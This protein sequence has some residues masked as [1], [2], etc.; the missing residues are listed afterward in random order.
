M[1]VPKNQLIKSIDIKLFWVP[2]NILKG[3]DQTS[4][5]WVPIPPSM[6]ERHNPLDFRKGVLPTAN[7]ISSS[8]CLSLAQ[9]KCWKVKWQF[10]WLKTLLQAISLFP[11]SN[12]TNLIGENYFK[13]CCKSW[14]LVIRDEDCLLSWVHFS[15]SMKSLVFWY[16]VGFLSNGFCCILC[17]SL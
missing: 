6:A 14:G 17:G 15:W 3:L 9:G 5:F 13:L 7:T 1:D 2:Q 4:S 11:Y 16:F 8:S 10:N 12:T